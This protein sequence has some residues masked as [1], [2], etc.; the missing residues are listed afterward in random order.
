VNGL[1]PPPCAVYH[2]AFIQLGVDVG[3]RGKIYNRTKA[4]ALP[5]IRH[6]H[7]EW[8]PKWVTE[9]KYRFKADS[10]QSFINDSRRRREYFTEN[11]GQNNPGNKIRYVYKRLKCPFKLAVGYFV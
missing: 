9:E 8:K 7:R 11:T 4:E 1:L 10:H 6:N 2:G 5:Y 3:E